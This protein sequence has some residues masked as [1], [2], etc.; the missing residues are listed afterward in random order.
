MGAG[1]LLESLKWKVR[2]Y[3]KNEAHEYIW[4]TCKL[5]EGKLIRDKYPDLAFSSTLH[6]QSALHL[7]YSYLKTLQS[8]FMPSLS[9]SLTGNG[10]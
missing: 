10:C 3:V 2:L 8:S 9:T 1:K 7:H 4:L 6:E 5:K